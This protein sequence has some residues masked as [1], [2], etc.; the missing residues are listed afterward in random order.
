M[1]YFI[2]LLLFATYLFSASIEI[3]GNR[4]KLIIGERLKIKT[5][6]NYPEN[7]QIY[8]PDYEGETFGKFERVN[9]KLLEKKITNGNVLEVWEHNYTTFE[10]PGE[11]YFGPVH[12]EIKG[13]SGSE[14]LKSDSL[15]IE[16]LSI[17][18]TGSVTTKDSLGNK[19]DIPFDSLK[20][21]L[22]IKGVK[23]YELSKNEKLI[24]GSIIGGIILTIIIIY[25]LVKKRKTGSIKPV[26]K[27]KIIPAHIVALEKLRNLER[28][29]L[30]SKGEF[31]E[32][33]VEISILIREYLEA[34]Y[35]FNAAEIPTSDILERM[36]NTLDK[37]LISKLEDLLNLTD[38]VKFAKH[39][40]LAEDLQK[41][42]GEAEKFIDKTKNDTIEKEK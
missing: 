32:F 25:L 7:S 36:N 27:V 28:K 29:N 1:K 10:E 9:S 42:V 22:P 30:L 37:N 39:I 16:V 35:K 18:K 24:I 14:I 33:S 5:T 26:K 19:I 17:L 40:P 15:K 8:Y 12:V 20:S 4:D 6:I 23:G 2:I 13:K 11:Y 41:F 31:K 3:D 21:I 34:R 38:L